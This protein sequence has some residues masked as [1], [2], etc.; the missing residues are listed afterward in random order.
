MNSLD[1][2]QALIAE[3]YNAV[4]N[5]DEKGV[6]RICHIILEQGID[7]YEAVTKA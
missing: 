3:L 7:A 1:R 2:S 5:M 6:V 4:V